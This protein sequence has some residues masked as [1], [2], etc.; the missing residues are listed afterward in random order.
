MSEKE[1]EVST[2]VKFFCPT[3]GEEYGVSPKI[4]QVNKA[5]GFLDVKF[6]EIRLA[7]ECDEKRR[8]L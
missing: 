3:C 4:K 2:G 7:H 5:G 6:E 1:G 8:L